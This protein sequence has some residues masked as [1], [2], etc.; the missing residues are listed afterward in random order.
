MAPQCDIKRNMKNRERICD[1][2]QAIIYFVCA[3]AY[4]LVDNNS[5]L[6]MFKLK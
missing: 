5:V 6:L 2:D 4:D 1:F 3:A